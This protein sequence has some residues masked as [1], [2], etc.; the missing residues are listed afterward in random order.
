MLADQIDD[1]LRPRFLSYES[2]FFNL[3]RSSG[4]DCEFQVFNVYLGDFPPNIDACDAYVIGGSRKGVYD[5]DAWIG[6]LKDFVRELVGANKKLLGIC[7]G[8]Q[9]IAGALGGRVELAPNGWQ[10]G[11]QT[12][13][14]CRS[15]QWLDHGYD[16]LR[17]YCFHQDQVIEMPKEARG[18]V[19]NDGCT[20]AG[21]VI[22]DNVLTLQ[23]HPEFQ[24]DYVECLVQMRRDRL[25]RKYEPALASLDTEVHLDP[26]YRT[27]RLFLCS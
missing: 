4:I 13:E 19:T 27:L 18:F 9:I 21:Y 15:I 23:S 5:K 1:A 7:F 16:Q 22:G 25:E 11:V 12:Y 24:R 2:M 3:I 14:V 26:V 20:Y 17:L 10:V 6:E 8:H